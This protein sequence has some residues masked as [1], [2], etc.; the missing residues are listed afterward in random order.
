MVYEGHSNSYSLLSTGEFRQ[1]TEKR[2]TRST[3][4]VFFSFFLNLCF[5]SVDPGL[6][7]P[8]P[9]KGNG[10][11]QDPPIVRFHVNWKESDHLVTL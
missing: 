6:G 10:P 7:A 8:V 2:K 5:S 1:N 9:L 3:P 4:T 11:N